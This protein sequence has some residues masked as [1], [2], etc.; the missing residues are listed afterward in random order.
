MSVPLTTGSRVS[1]RDDKSMVKQNKNLIAYCSL[2]CPKCYKMTVSEAAI[3]LQKE[4]KNPHICG[5]FQFLSK[6][7]KK[8]LDK[9]IKLHCPKLCK[10]GGGDKNCLIRKCCLKKKINGCWE[11]VDFKVCDKLKE[12]YVGNIKR[13]RK[14]GIN[15]YLK[16]NS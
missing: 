9:L 8:D 12:Q 16:A 3:K 11:C 10:A 15:N 7:F 5:K 14:I 2:Y 1:A 13:I 6:E 4:L